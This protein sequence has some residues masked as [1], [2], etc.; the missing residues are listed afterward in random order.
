MFFKL[1]NNLYGEELYRTDATPMGT[2]LLKDISP[3]PTSSE[4]VNVP[5]SYSSNYQLSSEINGKFIFSAASLSSNDYEL[6]ETD[7]TSNGT[8][9]IQDINPGIQGSMPFS[10]GF[11]LINGHYIFSATSDSVGLELWELDTAIASSIMSS[12]NQPGKLKL[13]PNPCVRNSEVELL[14]S[15]DFKVKE[16]FVYDINGKYIETNISVVKIKHL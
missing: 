9:E 5:F 11:M 14:M 7:G 1:S 12:T 15:D 4:P 16:L 6:W 8:R 10:L 13:Y 2:Y 3:G